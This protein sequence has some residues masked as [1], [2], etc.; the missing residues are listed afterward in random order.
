MILREHVVE[1]GGVG[2]WNIHPVGDLQFGAPG[3]D[4]ALW[5]DCVAKIKA[6]PNA[7]T[8]GMGDYS[9]HWRPTNQ[10]KLAQAFVGDS[11]FKESID[12]L[13]QAHNRKIFDKLAPIIKKGRCLGLLEGHH[14]HTYASGFT[15]T[16]ELCQMLG[17]PYLGKVAYIRLVF[18][19]GRKKGRH[20]P[21][22]RWAMKIHAQHGDGG[23]AFVGPDI[24]NLERK[25]TP[26]WN[27][28]LFLRGH[29][30]KAWSAGVPLHD[31]NDYGK[32][33]LIIK[34]KWMV[35]TGGFM[36]GYIENRETYVSASN[37]PPAR[38]GYVTVHVQLQRHE[39][40]GD[41]FKLS[42]TQ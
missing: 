35:N 32:P 4:D 22:H 18:G 2:T 7:L 29:S 39:T 33:R 37:M 11:D 28:D 9:D 38:L 17:V 30:T 25:T 16:Q 27:A 13:Y 15:S 12:E 21:S 42:V 24:A 36:A 5:K 1:C 3:F 34:E 20:Y 26:Y 41:I 14:F 10:K 40:A 6:D 19:A 23:A 31:M 8:I